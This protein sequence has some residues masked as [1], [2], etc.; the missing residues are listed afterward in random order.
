MGMIVRSKILLYAVT[1]SGKKLMLGVPGRMTLKKDRGAAAL[2]T[3]RM[4][5]AGR[6]ERLISIEA[7]SGADRIFSGIVDEEIYT[8]TGDSVILEIAAR[9]KSALLLDN[10]AMPQQMKNPTL[11]FFSRRFL[12][13]YGFSII[14][15]NKKSAGEVKAKRGD[16]IYLLLE[17]MLGDGYGTEPVIKAD[18]SVYLLS[19]YE[20]REVDIDEDE[21]IRAEITKKNSEIVSEYILPDTVTRAFN[22]ALVNPYMKGI[23]RIC[24]IDNPG[25]VDFRVYNTVKLTV[26]GYKDID[27]FDIVRSEAG[28]EGAAVSVKFTRDSGGDRTEVTYKAVESEENLCG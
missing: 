13:P 4:R 25:E 5:V 3:A 23:S 28:G 7:F 27:V 8:Q 18:G 22:T 11:S 9:D 12:E 21:L 6:C 15:K 17:R 10:E 1:V 16:S 24:Y 2:L 20:P 26:S 19:E 14:S